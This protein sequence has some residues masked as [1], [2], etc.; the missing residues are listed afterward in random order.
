MNWLN[1]NL[2][3]LRSPAYLGSTP[4]ERATWLQ[5]LAYCTDQENG[6]RIAGAAAWKDRQ[7]Q[8]TCGV[9]AR[10]V[11]AAARL[12]VLEGGDVCVAFYPLEKQ[13]E[14]QARRIAATD[15]ANR[16]WH[17][18]LHPGANGNEEDSQPAGKRAARSECAELAFS[19]GSSVA[20]D[21]DASGITAGIA[22]GITSGITG[23]IAPSRAEE[24]GNEKENHNGNARPLSSPA[25]EAGMEARE[26]GWK[27]DF[28]KT[29]E[30]IAQGGAQVPPA[31]QDFCEWWWEAQEGAGW[32]DAQ[33]RRI[34]N[35]KSAFN[36]AWRAKVHIT[37]E[38]DARA[39]QH[40]AQPG[41]GPPRAMSAY[42]VNTKLAAIEN[43]LGSIRQKARDGRSGDGL[44]TV[45]LYTPEEE[46]RR[47]QLL[48]AKEVLKRKLTE[49]G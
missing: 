14:V 35:W 40:A 23:G 37:Q 17:G 27:N 43:E 38:R 4:V 30:V 5:L 15:A 45:K 3:T 28:P 7:W 11:R 16:R 47:E 48:A 41:S 24:N 39:R 8:Q 21:A 36:A 46:S 22:N 12:V 10:E 20:A 18:K 13:A 33:G 44:R 6:G 42:E 31:P 25:Q 1:I 34:H 49:V 2:S 29:G 9:T 26:G 32:I 19:N